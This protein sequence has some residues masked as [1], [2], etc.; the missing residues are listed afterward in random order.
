MSNQWLDESVDIIKS[1]D[2]YTY[3]VEMEC[4]WADHLS[5]SYEAFLRDCEIEDELKMECL[6]FNS[7]R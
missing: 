3:K 7:I 5:Y 1:T 4:K 6:D 2:P